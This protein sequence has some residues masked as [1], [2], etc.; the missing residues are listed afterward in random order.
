MSEPHAA[1]VLQRAA[2]PKTRRSEV[3]RHE[4]KYRISY[5]EKAALELRL[6]PLLRRDAHAKPG[7][8]RI[9]SLY[10]D[11]WWNSAYGE[12]EA[13]VFLR[14][15]YR[16]LRGDYG[17]LL[18]SPQNLCR[19]FYVECVSHV[20]RPRVLVDYEREAWVLD[21]GTV[22]ITFDQNV[23][24]AVGGWDLFDPKLPTL[25]VLDPGTLVLEV[26]FTE[27]LP[28]VLRQLLPPKAQEWTAVSKYVLCADKTAYRHGFSG[29]ND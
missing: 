18:V 26:K 15:K 29:W 14:K 23:R 24:A 17:V 21:E 27:F 1:A 11:D 3:Y 25:P 19:E 28:E 5:A 6:A 7:G 12:K 2:P 10:F 13:G 8:Y 4:L 20:L 22:R 16:I 9:R